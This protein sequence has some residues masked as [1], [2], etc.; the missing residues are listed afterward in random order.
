[1]QKND[2]NFYKNQCKNAKLNTTI[3][4]I[5]SAYVNGYYCA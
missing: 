5:L 1:M 2:E 3:V 4:K